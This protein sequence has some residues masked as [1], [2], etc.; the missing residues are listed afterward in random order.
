MI[1]NIPTSTDI[2]CVCLQEHQCPAESC[3]RPDGE[4]FFPPTARLRHHCF[5]HPPSG[6]DQ[7]CLQ[8]A[9]IH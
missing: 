4:Q 2:S 5:P 9:A 8:V 3:G 1:P 6:P 7:L